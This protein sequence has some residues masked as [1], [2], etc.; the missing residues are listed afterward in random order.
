MTARAENVSI[1]L[2]G[3]KIL[4]GISFEIGSGESALLTGKTGSGKTLLG[5]AMCGYLPMWAG[6]W[7]LE[8]HISLFGEETIQ[9]DYRSDIGIVFE[10][11]YSQISGLK[12]T[13]AGELAFP[14][15]CKGVKPA[16]IEMEVNR[17]AKLFNI[18]HILESNLNTSSGGEIQRVITACALIGNPRFLFLDRFLT[19][20]DSGFR[21]T[22]MNIV[23]GHVS[24]NG[25]AFIAAEDSWLLPDFDFN[26]HI[27][28]SEEASPPDFGKLQN[29]FDSIPSHESHNPLLEISELCFSYSGDR[30]I[31]DNLNLTLS[32]GE[33]LLVSGPN[34]AGKTTL[35]KILSGLLKPVS[36]LVSLDKHSYQELSADNII[37][38]VG[39]ALQNPELQFCRKTV[40]EELLLS[41]KWGNSPIGLVEILGLGSLMD[42]HPFMLTKAEKKRLGITLAYGAQKKLII[43]DEPTQYQDSG[44]FMMTASAICQMA[45]EGK[46]V[47]V[48]SHDPR[49]AE[50]F[51][52]IRT[53][54]LGLNL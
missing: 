54:K 22:L 43:L 26:R 42:S 50:A 16:E 52:G 41:E 1:T 18:M 24:E 40:H 11:P 12:K 47:I 32:G 27:S 33:I 8:G 10:E 6:D 29:L 20:I 53:L 21:Q 45:S 31:L 44:N 48:I 17:Y 5:I 30:K 49:F 35:A 3:R 36:G 39:F 19:E 7:N 2:S 13:V 23:S 15:E 28:L 14:L 25:G 34:G 38:Q 46:A 4:S 51:S 9:G 37:S